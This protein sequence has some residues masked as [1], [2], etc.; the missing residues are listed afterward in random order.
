MEPFA[1]HRTILDPG[2]V[3]GLPGVT[4]HTPIPARET[5]LEGTKTML[6][7]KDEHLKE[8]V[9]GR[10]IEVILPSRTANTLGVLAMIAAVG[11]VVF[12]WL[13]RVLWGFLAAR[14]GIWIVILGLALV[15]VLAIFSQILSSGRNKPGGLAILVLYGGGILSVI[16]DHILA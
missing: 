10:S 16:I 3:R 7:P 9:T 4:K 5:P 13:D 15:H 11:L 6:C 14:H 12:F 2:S 8:L 1:T